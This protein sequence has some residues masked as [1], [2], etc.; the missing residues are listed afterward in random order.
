[1]LLTLLLS[2][3]LIYMSTTQNTARI[4][5]TAAAYDKEV[6]RLRAAWQS[7]ENAA[8]AGESAE[9]VRD[10]LAAAI[11]CAMVFIGLIAPS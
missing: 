5:P 6:T 8:A 11:T 4:V 3:R 10:E 7:L 1:M 9:S 2:T